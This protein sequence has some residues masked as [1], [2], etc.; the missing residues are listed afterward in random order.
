MM[1]SGLI[2][3]DVGIMIRNIEEVMDFCSCLA[4]G[5]KRVSMSLENFFQCVSSAF[6]FVF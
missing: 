2:V 4:S 5:G 3:C 1:F 6:Q